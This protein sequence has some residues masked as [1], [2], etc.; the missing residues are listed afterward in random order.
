MRKLKTLQKERYPIWNGPRI[1]AVVC[2]HGVLILR[3]VLRSSGSLFRLFLSLGMEVEE[4]VYCA[5]IFQTPVALE[6]PKLYIQRFGSTRSANPTHFAAWDTVFSKPDT[7]FKKPETTSG[8]PT[9]PLGYCGL[10]LDGVTVD[11]IPS[12][13][14]LPTF[15]PP[16]RRTMAELARA[17]DAPPRY[18]SGAVFPKR[19]TAGDNKIKELKAGLA[20]LVAETKLTKDA[21]ARPRAPK[22]I[23]ADEMELDGIQMTLPGVQVEPD[24]QAYALEQ[25]NDGD[26]N[27]ASQS[28]SASLGNLDVDDDG[29]VIS[30]GDSDVGVPSVNSSEDSF[31]S[32]VTTI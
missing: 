29:A 12:A 26:V 25:E 16:Q 7:F 9:S 2:C 10:A 19:A 20:I 15:S 11:P 5:V 18:S 31:N 24:V 6:R 3:E 14:L 30:L 27:R 28:K 22:K 23:A 17:F 13:F 1:L 8:H 21:T 32:G 4:E